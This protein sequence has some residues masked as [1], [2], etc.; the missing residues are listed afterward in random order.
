M[1][2]VWC[3]NR[4]GPGE[5]GEGRLAE[6]GDEE[7]VDLSLDLSRVTNPS[8]TCARGAQAIRSAAPSPRPR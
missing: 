6:K 5:D 1:G 4:E 8:R 2:N 3:C 7:S